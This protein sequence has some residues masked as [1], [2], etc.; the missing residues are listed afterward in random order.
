LFVVDAEDCEEAGLEAGAGPTPRFCETL[1]AD[2]AT[3]ARKFLICCS[4]KLDDMMSTEVNRSVWSG[5]RRRWMKRDV[6]ED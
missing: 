2:E 3:S 6:V 1:D 5:W 4:S